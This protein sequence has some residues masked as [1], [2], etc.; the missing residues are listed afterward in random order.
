MKYT[1]KRKYTIKEYTELQKKLCN[2]HNSK[3]HSDDIIPFHEWLIEMSPWN[4]T[5]YGIQYNRDK[6]G[7][8]YNSFNINYKEETYE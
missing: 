4:K 2:K 6:D 3:A 7:L 5:E 1:I 8:E